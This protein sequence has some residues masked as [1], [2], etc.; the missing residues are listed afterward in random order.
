[1][2]SRISGA[3]VR[4]SMS[5]NAASSAIAIAASPSVRD[6]PQPKSSALTIAY[7]STI[8]P[9]VTV[10]AP[11]RSTARCVFIPRDSGT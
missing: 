5:T 6:E 8:R 9:A 1:M 3:R 7:T 4:L 2:P 11:G 10:T